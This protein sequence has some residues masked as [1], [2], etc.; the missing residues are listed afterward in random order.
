MAVRLALLAGHYRQDREWFPATLAEAE[1]RLARWRQAV[2][3]A[4][5]P[6]AEPVLD[7][8]RERLADDLDTP[9]ALAAVDRWAEEALA[10]GGPSASAPGLVRDLVDALLGVAL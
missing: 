9:A 3:L 7:R 1:T 2:A 6:A 10:R 5:G 8:V 4:S